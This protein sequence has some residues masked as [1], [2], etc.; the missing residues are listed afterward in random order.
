MWEKQKQTAL[1]Y[2]KERQESKYLIEHRAQRERDLHDDKTRGYDLKNC[3][4]NC[5]M[6]RSAW[7]IRKG[8]CNNCD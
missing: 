5:R 1:E 3:C 8:T 7:E 2:Q 4:P 6:I